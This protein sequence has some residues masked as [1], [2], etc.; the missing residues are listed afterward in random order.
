MYA[1][2]MSYWT[3]RLV[4]PIPSRIAVPAGTT[5]LR[6]VLVHELRTCPSCGDATARAI[7]LGDG[8]LLSQCTRCE[9][10]Y[11]PSYADP[12]E[13][14]QDG[15]LKGERG[16]FGLDLSHPLFQVYLE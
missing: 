13:I 2:S 12:G 10:I 4:N 3:P 14:Y 8:H 15:Y 16:S 7:E 1:E 11:A 9:Q 5:K 6:A